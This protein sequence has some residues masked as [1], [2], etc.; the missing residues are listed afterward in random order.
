MS[1]LESKIKTLEDENNKLILKTDALEIAVSIMSMALDSVMG[2][3]RGTLANSFEET[4][5]HSHARAVAESSL[6]EE[7]F[8]KLKAEVLSLL[9]KQ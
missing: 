9:G 2:G 4:F 6:N 7:Y 3:Q 5:N 8:Q 1:D